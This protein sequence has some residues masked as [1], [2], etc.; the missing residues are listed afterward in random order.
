[1][2]SAL[3]VACG[4]TASGKILTETI[5]WGPLCFLRAFTDIRKC[6]SRLGL[7]NWS[8]LDI[9]KKKKRT[10]YRYKMSKGFV[11]GGLLVNL[12]VQVRDW[13]LPPSLLGVH[14]RRTKFPPDIF[15]LEK[16]F[17]NWLRMPH[18]GGQK[19]ISWKKKKKNDK[20]SPLLLWQRYAERNENVSLSEWRGNSFDANNGVHML[21]WF[22]WIGL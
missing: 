14:L 7:Y 22:H 16:Y 2:L 20:V 17:F 5:V 12:R 10:L 1:M 18:R 8:F 3:S 19:N 4:A 13:A 9:K 21:L 11:R 15:E 6:F